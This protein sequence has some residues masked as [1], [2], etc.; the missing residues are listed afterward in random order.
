MSYTKTNWQTGDL[1]TAE[2]LNHAEQGIYDNSLTVG[3]LIVNITNGDGRLVLDKT[4]NEINNF[5]GIVMTVSVDDS[6][7]SIDIVSAI[8]QYENDYVISLLAGNTDFTAS[9]ATD[10]PSALPVG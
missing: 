6:S 4:W 2:L 8:Y 1:I 10:Y 9:S 5:N 7:K 3:V